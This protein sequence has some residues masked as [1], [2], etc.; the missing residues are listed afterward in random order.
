MKR[1][2]ILAIFPAEQQ[3][4]YTGAVNFQLEKRPVKVFG[5]QSL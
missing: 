4:E 5:G 2:N 1:N 3:F